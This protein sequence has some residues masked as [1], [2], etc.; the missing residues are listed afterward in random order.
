[1]KVLL[2]IGLFIALMITGYC[3]WKTS[4][5][6]HK[7]APSVLKILWVGFG[8]V[9]FY[10]FAVMTEVEWIA[11][12]SYNIYY[13]AVGWL[14]YFLLYFSLE[15]NGTFMEEYVR[16]DF[17]FGLLILDSLTLIWNMFSQNLFSLKWASKYG[18]LYV[19]KPQMTELFFV[20][21]TFL[22]LCAVMCMIGLTQRFLTAP[23]FYRAKYF[24]I[25]IIFACMIGLNIFGFVWLV[26]Y[27]ILGYVAEVICIYYCSFVYT[28][29]RLLSK[30]LTQVTENMLVG[31]LALDL[32]GKIIYYNK[33]AESFLD[34]DEFLLNS[35]GISLE[36]WCREQAVSGAQD[37]EVVETFYRGREPLSFKIQLQRIMDDRS[38]LQGSYYIIQDITE[39]INQLKKKQYLSTHDRLTRL[40]TKEYFYEQAE[41][42]IKSHMDEE[43]LIVCTD[44][45]DFKMIN[46]FF[47]SRVGDAVL[48]NYGEKIRSGAAKMIAYGRLGNDHFAVLIKKEDFN[49]ALFDLTTKEAFA[50]ATHY[51]VSYQMVTYIGVYEVVERDLL[52]SVM[53]GRARMALNTIK[54]N[55]KQKVAYYDEALRDNI[56][57]EQELT[58]DLI[59]A[60]EEE[61]LQMYLQPQTTAEGKVLGA[62][63]LIRWHHPIKGI[64]PP[65]EFIPIF[66]KN[67]M[68]TEVDKCIWEM[69]CRQLREWNKHG[70]KNVYLSVNIS[71]RDFY[72]LDI[73]QIFSG[74][75]E[76]YQINPKQLKL[77]ITESAVMLDFARQQELIEKLRKTGFVVEMDD[78]GS[79]YS[80]LNMLK[81]IYVDVLKLDMAFLK[82][83]QNTERGRTILRMVIGLAKNLQIPVISE[84]VET[85]EQ[86][87][88]L[89]KLG[90]EMFQGYYFAKP[91]DVEQFEVKYL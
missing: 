40:Y 86:L 88:F 73:Y 17:V 25:A 69:A 62:E 60:V 84:G 79:A 9:F 65:D 44:I 37:G 53:C 8:M 5:I 32:E 55:R 27:S 87:Q 31:V 29:Q 24:V 70:K 28:P 67:G 38:Q 63:A 91:M 72:F 43:L 42:Y 89:K 57:Y 10:I 3:L 2:F 58:K 36:G 34:T 54:D 71:P 77:E 20:H 21:Y 39:E 90:C 66:E 4:E 48:Q 75:I 52:V 82:E 45:R 14:I 7:L 6:N 26:D 13:I 1:M 80:S 46:D 11:R 74:L 68:I 33:T 30:T 22:L 76:K 49:P 23:A 83:S 16:K 35:K 51:E 78:F 18:Q 59:R 64:L 47:G 61:Q 81:D 56:I 19:Y 50:G 41:N 12:I 15:L 85:E